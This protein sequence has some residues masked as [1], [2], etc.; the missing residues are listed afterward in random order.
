MN[1]THQDSRG[2]TTLIGDLAQQVTT[3]LQTEGRLLRAEISEKL[4]KVGAGAIQVLG[5]AV[6]L[7]AALMVLLQALVIA[8]AEAGLGAGWSSLLVGVVVAILGVIL[9]RSGTASMNPAELTPDRTQSQLKQ[10]V[11]VVKDQLK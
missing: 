9:L 2:L 11:R 6:C 3:L 8:L 10:D 5:G 1:E 7:L 4:G